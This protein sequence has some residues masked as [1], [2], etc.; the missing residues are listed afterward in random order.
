M[1]LIISHLNIEKS[2]NKKLLPDIPEHPNW[3]FDIYIVY[4][5]FNAIL[6]SGDLNLLVR[7][8][9]S[10]RLNTDKLLFREKLKKFLLINL[11]NGTLPKNSKDLIKVFKLFKGLQ[12]EYKLVKYCYENI[13]GNADREFLVEIIAKNADYRLL[14][15]T[16]KRKT[17]S[18]LKKPDY[19]IQHLNT[20]LKFKNYSYLTQKLPALINEF[21]KS[22]THHLKKLEKMYIDVLSK[23]RRYSKLIQILK[24]G[25]YFTTITPEQSLR[26]QAELYIKKGFI[27]NVIGI[28]QSEN[29]GSKTRNILV[30]KI[31]DYYYSKRKYFKSTSYYSKV[32]F[33]YIKNKVESEVRWRI[34]FALM[35]ENQ[36]KDDKQ[37]NSIF[38]WSEAFNFEEL[39]DAARFCYW[40]NTF[41]KSDQVSDILSCFKKYPNTYYGLYALIQYNKSNETPYR[42][43]ALKY[44]SGNEKLAVLFQVLNNSYF[45][46]HAELTEYIIR[47]FMHENKHLLKY[48]ED[49]LKFLLNQMQY[50]VAI[51][52]IYQHYANIEKIGKDYFYKQ[53]LQYDYPL[54]YLHLV[55]Q[56]QRASELPKYIINAVIR[57]E[58]KIRPEVESRAGAVGLMQ[59]MP[60]TAIYLNKFLKLKGELDLKKPEVNI[61]IGAFYLKRLFKRYK[62]NLY[63]MLAAYNAGP[64]NANRWIKKVNIEQENYFLESI[65]YSETRNYVK[66]VLK[67]FYIYQILYEI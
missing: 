31:G 35:R 29:I 27:N 24:Q 46:N 7:F 52:L 65:S 37:L 51:S 54:A 42:L 23:K 61:K 25:H 66:R 11:E 16:L 15:N 26:I 5:K 14:S 3:I 43:K 62:G 41:I 39:E 30:L 58:S 67:S 55:K 63:H 18:V 13:I 48:Q 10:K 34:A 6:Q 36:K 19:L 8:I 32:D 59:L 40:N 1:K 20:Q 53:I 50:N 21:K 60:Q 2:Q 56:S 38:N 44:I 33:Q 45:E 22:E 12:K 47:K 9:E 64:T 4:S 57:E 49:F 28:L 17:E